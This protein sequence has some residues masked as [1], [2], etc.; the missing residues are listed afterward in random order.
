MKNIKKTWNYFK[1]C[2]SK[3]IGYACV[4]IIE[5]IISAILPI[6]SAKIILN[7]TNAIISQLI[8]SA[9]AILIITIILNTMYFFKGFLYQR[10]YK[11]V[12]INLQITLTKETLKLEINE[13]NKTGTGLFIDRINKDVQDIA[14]IFMEYA[15]WLSY[16]LTNIG[17]LIAIFTFNKYLFI[18]A[19]ITSIII[20]LINKKKLHK[21]YQIQKEIKKLQESKTSLTSELIRG[22]KDIKVLNTTNNILEQ[23][24]HKIVESAKE[25]IKMLNVRGLYVYLENNIKSLSDF[26]FIILGCVLYSNDLLT[27]PAF[28][29]IYNYQSKVKNLLNGISQILEYN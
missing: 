5:A 19:I 4:S 23:V 26:I 24:E 9:L 29:I 20:F 14:S 21:Q 2:K 8:L 16:I 1:E 25:E 17:V 3:L 7:I 22:I 13:I 18:Y 12:I 11:Q 28:I 27:I 15:Y 10:I 6:I